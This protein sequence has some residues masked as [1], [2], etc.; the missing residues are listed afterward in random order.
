MKDNLIKIGPTLLTVA[1]LLIAFVLL[2]VKS[3]TVAEAATE[4][5]RRGPSSGTDMGPQTY[6]SGN[7]A[8]EMLIL[9]GIA[10]WDNK[11]RSRIRI[12]EGSEDHR[13]DIENAYAIWQA[14]AAGRAWDEKIATATLTESTVDPFTVGALVTYKSNPERAKRTEAIRAS[15]AKRMGIIIAIDNNV[16]GHVASRRLVQVNWGGY[17]TFWD[18]AKNLEVVNASR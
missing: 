11:T 8:C 3:M 5:H 12:T 17:G 18:P 13:K 6:A 16:A 10:E 4:A 2:T 15:Q 9:A 14:K 7:T 1:E